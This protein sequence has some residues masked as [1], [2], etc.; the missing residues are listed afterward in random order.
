VQVFQE[1]EH[2]S[3]GFVLIGRFFGFQPERLHQLSYR[4]LSI[5][6]TPHFPTQGV[7]HYQLGTFGIKQGHTVHLRK[8]VG[9]FPDSTQRGGS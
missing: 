4:V 2:L 5:Q 3:F 9:D 8:R 6:A 1:Q 7:E